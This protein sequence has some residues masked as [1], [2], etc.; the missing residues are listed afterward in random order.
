MLGPVLLL[1]AWHSRPPALAPA[2]PQKVQEVE[3]E[4]GGLQSRLSE[5]ESE[6]AV[7]AKAAADAA[8]ALEESR[9]R[10]A[11]F[12]QVGVHGTATGRGGVEQ[13]D[14]C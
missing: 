10:L 4:I 14:C 11:K 13:R 6:R 1:T 9:G 12:A 3:V 8:A 7:R 5:L 2:A